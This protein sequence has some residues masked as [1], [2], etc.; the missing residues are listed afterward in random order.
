MITLDAKVPA[1]PI[2][3][4]WDH[5]EVRHEAGGAAQPAPLQGH[6][7]RHRPRRRRRRRDAR[8]ARLRRPRAS[9]STTRPAGP[10]RSPPRAASTRPRTTRATA[11][12][13][14]RLFYD[15]VKGGDYRA[16]EA[17]VYRLAE[18]S[19]D[20]ID[21]CVAQGVPF[22]REYGGL[23]DNRSFGGAQVT[24]HVLRP[25]PDRPAAAARR[26]PGARAARSHAGTVDAL[27]RAEMLDLVVKDGRAV[28]IVARHLHTGEVASALGPRRRAR[29][30]RLRQRLLPLDQRQGVATPPRSGGRTRRARCSP[31]PAS[32]RST[33]RASRR[34]TSSSRSSR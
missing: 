28:G 14:F 1:G 10:T 17:N 21:Q 2:E 15:T 26:L 31:T 13:I 3:E 33:R 9:R 29:H 12:R 16:R 18:V 30:R 23:L 34:A 25:G 22:A 11:T 27:P 7:R 6:R 8:R 24:P 32:R 19:V 4:K 20:I 5:E